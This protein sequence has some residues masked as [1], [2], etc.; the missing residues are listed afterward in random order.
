MRLRR[1]R[2]GDLRRAHKQRSWLAK[3]VAPWTA[4]TP[5]L[6]DLYRR[7]LLL[8]P[9]T[10]QLAVDWS[11][12]TPVRGSMRVVPYSAEPHNPQLREIQFQTEDRI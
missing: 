5:V 7:D 2:E 8:V 3:K 9:I 10:R 1:L 11:E 6:L 4:Q 12:W